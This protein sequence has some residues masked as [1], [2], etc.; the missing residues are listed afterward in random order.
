M[1][2]AFLPSLRVLVARRLRD[3]GFSQSRI[4]TLL[5]VTQASV[6]FYLSSNE[7]RA[8]SVLSSISIRKEESDKFASV[9]VEDVKRSATD[10]LETIE[11]LWLGLLGEGRICDAHKMASPDLADCDF[12]L[13][14]FGGGNRRASEAIED[15]SMAVKIVESSP[16]FYEVI[17]E[18]SVNIACLAGDSESPDDVVAV[19]G[20]IVKVKN[21]ARAMQRP[22]FAASRHMSR[23]L[24]LVRRRRKNIR[25]AINMKY[26]TRM[27]V[28][29][30]KLQL[31]V[32][33]LGGYP[34]EVSGDPTIGAISIKLVESSG[35][36]DAIVDEGGRG[37]EPNVYIFAGSAVEAAKKAVRAAELYSSG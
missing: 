31:R 36:F 33:K 12:C 9:L 1:V 23:V 2:N 20:R 25:A 8:Y 16:F 27:S 4:A 10:A 3:Q 29:L 7:A 17:P 24:L 13:R 11:D 14:R 22:A 28:V 18:V 21:R 6:S 34:R 26:D 32:L 30:K 5:G 19:P 37:I 15:V 35:P